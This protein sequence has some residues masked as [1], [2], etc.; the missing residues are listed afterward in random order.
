M[1]QPDASLKGKNENTCRLTFEI[2]GDRWTLRIIDAL[3]NGGVRF[4]ELQERLDINSATLTIKLKMLTALQ[5]ITRT[6]EASN[7]LPVTYSLTA[8]G[9]ELLPIYDGILKFGKKFLPK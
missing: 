7:R 4:C 1:P 5:L 8:L 2:F 3:R 6:K 9:T